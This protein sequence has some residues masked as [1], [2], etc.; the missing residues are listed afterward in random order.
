MK[1]ISVNEKLPEQEDTVFICGVNKYDDETEYE[2]FVDLGYY[3]LTEE[4]WCTENDWEEGQ[5]FI[6]IMF[7]KPIKYPKEPDKLSILEQIKL[8]NMKEDF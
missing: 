7:W 4:K 2:T 5:D 3:D 8:N 1:W 6:Q